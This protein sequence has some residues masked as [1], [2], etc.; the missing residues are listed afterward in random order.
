M[1][2]GFGTSMSNTDM[3]IF[4]ADGE[5]TVSDRYSSGYREPSVDAQ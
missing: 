4:Q 3:V 1:A 2:I 5:G